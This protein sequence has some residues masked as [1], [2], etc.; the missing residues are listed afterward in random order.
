MP[1]RTGP[2]NSGS[3]RGR[4]KK[5]ISFAVWVSG[6]GRQS[7]ED[8]RAAYE[9]HNR[10]GPGRKNRASA[11]V[12]IKAPPCATCRPEILPAND[13]AVAAY[14]RCSDQWIIAPSGL[15]MGLLATSVNSVIEKM[16]V[17]DELE[18]FDAVRRIASEVAGLL[19]KEAEKARDKQ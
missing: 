17:A 10:P 4:P 11:P 14:F 1:G 19:A 16:Q 7:C 3:R 18:C 5:L 2:G 6:V 9:A 12:E 15:R 8:C 13:E